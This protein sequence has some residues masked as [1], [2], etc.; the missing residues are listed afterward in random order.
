MIVTYELYFGNFYLLDT[1]LNINV[2]PGGTMA[3]AADAQWDRRR[4]MKSSLKIKSGIRP[5]Q[6]RFSIARSVRSDRGPKVHKN[7]LISLTILVTSDMS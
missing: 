7:V 5:G 6:M 3:A 1:T 4:N 2:R